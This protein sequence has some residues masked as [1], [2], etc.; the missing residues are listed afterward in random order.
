[1]LRSLSIIAW[2]TCR[3][4]RQLHCRTLCDKYTV[5]SYAENKN[6]NVGLEHDSSMALNALSLSRAIILRPAHHS[7]NRRRYKSTRAEA[8]N[9]QS[10]VYVKEG[11]NLSPNS[12]AEEHVPTSMHQN[13]LNTYA[14]GSGAS[15]LAEPSHHELKLLRWSKLIYPIQ[16]V[17]IILFYVCLYEC[18]YRMC[19]VL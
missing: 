11:A 12:V 19:L 10:V 7:S 13:I 8:A 3:V 9:N 4:T 15:M 16:L 18:M 2:S 14:A 6:K 5:I 1:M 17:S